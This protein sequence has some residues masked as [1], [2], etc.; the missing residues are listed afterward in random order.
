MNCPPTVTTETQ[1]VL[2]TIKVI[3]NGKTMVEQ[4]RSQLQLMGSKKR[5]I[6]TSVLGNK[7]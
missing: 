5:K 6:M 7:L 4:S 2:I 3:R 1:L